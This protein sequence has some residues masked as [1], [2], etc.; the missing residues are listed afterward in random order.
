MFWESLK[1]SLTKL[2]HL[3]PELV[4]IGLH[5]SIYR[6]KYTENYTTQY[7]PVNNDTV[8]QYLARQIDVLFILGGL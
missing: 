4:C 6:A 7:K 1:S 2:S 5:I 8:I 3:H